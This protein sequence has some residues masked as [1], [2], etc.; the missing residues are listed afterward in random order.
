MVMVAVMTM[1]AVLM[2]VAMMVVVPI[3]ACAMLSGGPGLWSRIHAGWC[4][5]RCCKHQAMT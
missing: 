2:P 3:M 1:M 5:S 4:R